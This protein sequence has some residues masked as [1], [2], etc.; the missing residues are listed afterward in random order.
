M[1]H[2]RSPSQIADRWRCVGNA[3]IPRRRFGVNPRTGPLSVCTIG[4]AATCACKGNIAATDS[5]HPNARQAFAICLAGG[6]AP[7]VES[8][9]IVSSN[10]LFVAGVEIRREGNWGVSKSPSFANSD[11]YNNLDFNFPRLRYFAAG[12]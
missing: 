10:A 12:D 4:P 11:T 8:K 3:R 5:I 9:D 7:R 2:W 1:R 6:K